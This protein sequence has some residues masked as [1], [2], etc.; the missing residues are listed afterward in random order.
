MAVDDGYLEYILDQLSLVEGVSAR[1]MFGGAGLYAEGTMFGLIADEELYFR[2]DDGNRQ[3]YL[4][5]ESH[6]FQ[7]WEDK[8]MTM[9]YHLVPEDVMESPPELA[10][11]ARDALAAAKRNKKK[12]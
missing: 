7:P 4:D 8:P 11:W 3:V 1:K 9:P 6:A 5:R 10:E 2:T 12:K